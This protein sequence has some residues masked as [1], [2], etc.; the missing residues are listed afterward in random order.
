MAFRLE[1]RSLDKQLRRV[2][3]KELD[4]AIDSLGAGD[5]GSLRIHD[6][7]KHIKK[8]RAVVKLLRGPLGKNY[9]QEN[10]RLRAAGNRLSDLRDAE[11]M[12]QTLED[13]RGRFVKVMTPAIEQAI[14][15]GLRRHRHE[16]HK[17]ASRNARQAL[18]FLKGSHATLPGR[19]GDAARFRV[20]G[21]GFIRVYE[22]SKSAL[23]DLTPLSCAAQLH[24]WRRRV[25][26]HWYHVRLFESRQPSIRARA[27]RLKAL[28]S[29]LGEDH[30]LA[31][32]TDRLLENPDRFGGAR[33][34]ALV[35]GCIQ[36]RQRALRRRAL[37]S[38]Q[39]LFRSK[40]VHMHTMLDQWRSNAAR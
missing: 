7:R 26:E 31:V 28:Q 24:A 1:R 21:R 18:G 9:A 32:L 15:S 5:V 22:R 14:A 35:L 34:S 38:G 25:K 40:P 2:V 29:T 37:A 11:V 4:A 39:Q 12:L 23:T 27:R 8:V 30:N 20:V 13:L 6:A 17:Q 36:K 10:A 33:T 3:R 19:V 16:T